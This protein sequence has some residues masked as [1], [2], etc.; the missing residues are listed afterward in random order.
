MAA[1]RRQRLHS[2]QQ[3]II[4]LEKRQQSRRSGFFIPLFQNAIYGLAMVGYLK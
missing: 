1:G 4:H 3:A 2:A